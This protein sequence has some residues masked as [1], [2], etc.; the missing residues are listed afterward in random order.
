MY[1]VIETGGKQYRVEVGTELEVERLDVEAGEAITIDRV[2]LVADGGEASIGRP[3]VAD[4]VVNAEVVRQDRG[5]K[6]ISF[7]YRPKARSRVKK[8]HRQELTVLRVTDVRLDDR[9][10]AEGERKAEEARRTE[11]ERLEEAAA[12]QAAADAELAAKLASKAKPE[13]AEA[14]PRGRGPGRGAP[15]AET[16]DAALPRMRRRP[17]RAVRRPPRPSPRRAKPKRE[18]DSPHEKGS[19][20]PDGTQESRI[21]LEERPRQR[22]PAARRQGRRRPGRHGGLD[23][24]SPARHDL[25]CRH[26]H[27]PRP[28]LHRL[29]DD[30]AGSA[31]TM[32]RDKKRVRI[33]ADGAQPPKHTAEAAAAARLSR[34]H[35]QRR[36]PPAG[37]TVGR[38]RR[39][40][41]VK[42]RSIPST[43]RPTCIA[44]PAA[45]RS[46]V[47]STRQ[48]LRVDVCSNCHPFYTGKQT[49]IDTAGQVER[50]QKR[51]ERQ[52]APAASAA[53]RS[54]AAATARREPGNQQVDSAACHLRLWRPGPRG[55]RPHARPRR[56]RGRHAPSQRRDR[57]GHRAPDSGFHASRI[58][59]LPFVRGLVVLYETL[60]VG[61]RWLVRSGR[62]SRLPIRAWSWAAARSP[63]CSSSPW[64]RSSASSSCCR[65]CWRAPRRVAGPSRPAPRRGRDP[66]RPVHRL[67]AADLARRRLRRVFQY[68]GAEH[69]TIHA[70]E[71]GDPL[72]TDTS[73]ATPRPTSAAAP[74]SW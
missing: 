46:T 49:I 26:R 16:K 28:R 41:P 21:Q 39:S 73:A 64:S 63:R 17:A 34:P 8:G 12:R 3:L 20:S 70:L 18:P 71:H 44:R 50:F 60:I 30:P 56:N 37:V 14:A 2:L 7:K 38:R 67:P 6:L 23:P 33:E 65:C 13:P 66:G 22:R 61:S 57:M 68:H 5:E 19:R 40:R 9:S 45:R 62:A 69:M 27:R 53:S 74:S 32:P 58:A 72:T 55:G 48:E 4:A 54:R 36:R 11:R 59:R 35:R 15:T 43:T 51:L 52:S 29:R 31:S 42:P 1:A 25:P 10:A 24:R 47:G